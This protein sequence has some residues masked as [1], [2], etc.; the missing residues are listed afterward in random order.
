MHDLGSGEPLVYTVLAS[1]QTTL[2]GIALTFDFQHH[3]SWSFLYST[4]ECE[5]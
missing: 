5:R 2:Y 3:M 1:L 4:I